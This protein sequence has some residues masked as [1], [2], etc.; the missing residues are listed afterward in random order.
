MVISSEFRHL[1]TWAVTGILAGGILSAG[2]L[3]GCK[4]TD[5]GGDADATATT[6]TT[7]TTTSEAMPDSTTDTS[8]ADTTTPDAG[9]STE[10]ANSS[11]PEVDGN[12]FPNAT[13]SAA[14]SSINREGKPQKW[15]PFPDSEAPSQFK[16][17]G[18]MMMV[19]NSE[20]QTLTPFVSRDAYATR[21]YREVLEPLIWTDVDEL[22]WVPGLAKSWD[23]SDD[24]LTITYH[25]FENATFSDGHPVTAEDVVFSFDLIMNPDIDAPVLRSYIESNV[26]SYRVVDPHTVEFTMVEPY[27]KALEITG[28][29]WVLPKHVYG[30]YSPDVYNKQIR[31]VCVGSGPWRLENWDKGNRITFARN[32]NYWGPKAAME[33][34]SIR[35]I[36]SDLSELQEFRANNVDMIG[37]S[38]EQWAAHKDS[39]WL[40]E[41]GEAFDYF[42][43]LGGYS[44]I[45]YNLRL[46]KLSDKRVR[47]AL[48]LLLDRQEIIDTLRM[49]IGEVVSG[50]FYFAGDQTNR[51]VEPWPYDPEWAAELLLEAGWEDT[52]GDGILD[53][54]LDGDEFRDP[55]QITFLAPS[56]S[57]FM[58]NLQL[59]VKRQFEE[60]GIEIILD[61][62][63]WS[64]FEERLTNRQFEMV[65]LAWTGN[66]ESDPYQIWHSS[67]AENR[68][69]NY[70]GYSNKEVDDL[71]VNARKT[72]DR[73]ARMKM[74][75]RVHELLHEDQPYTFLFNRPSLVFVDGK[76]RFPKHQQR[77]TY[78]EWWIPADLQV[79]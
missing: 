17:G 58:K 39:E 54:D 36:D 60:A 25:L 52:D 71:I 43:P 41:K 76:Y 7:E 65:S 27:F 48:T 10:Q 2:S 61:T 5:G 19:W 79:D 22:R 38:P 31:E 20:P 32:E 62:L 14:T 73:N 47:R 72:M 44:Y 70:I 3:S 34:F 6:T 24:G 29:N 28:N 56:G 30:D 51:D 63:E 69:S 18:D 13:F 49:G 11:Q 40:A 77:L 9:D 53:K 50:P 46:P 42:S 75:H 15:A 45:G 1:K 16:P 21:V 66:S 64:V 67:Q 57:Q 37:P 12:R 35:F 26:K 68:G 4:K 59:Y 33:T 55:F 74:W 23:V 78:A 8:S